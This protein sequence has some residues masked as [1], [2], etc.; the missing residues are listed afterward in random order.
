M[1]SFRYLD[2]VQ[3]IILDMCFENALRCYKDKARHLL[4]FSGAFTFTDQIANQRATVP[5]SHNYPTS[6]DGKV[7]SNAHRYKPKYYVD[8][9]TRITAF[10]EI[11]KLAYAFPHWKEAVSR[12]CESKLRKKSK[13]A[14]DLGESERLAYER[15]GFERSDISAVSPYDWWTIGQP[16]TDRIILIITT[17]EMSHLYCAR[18]AWRRG[19]RSEAIWKP[20]SPEA[21]M[22]RGLRWTFLDDHSPETP[23]RKPGFWEGTIFHKTS[24]IERLLLDKRSAVWQCYISSPPSEAY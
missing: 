11:F 23:T 7:Y 9:H 13:L 6:V 1:A 21:L 22:R 2:N 5:R 8:T 10:S 14:A 12:I 16:D 24:S 15:W 4:G 17:Q 19:L 20:E 18:E 3:D